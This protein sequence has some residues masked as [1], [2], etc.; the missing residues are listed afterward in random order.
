MNQDKAFYQESF[1]LGVLGGGQL[2][3]MMLPIANYMDIRISILDPSSSA[4]CAAL[5]GDFVQ[6][7]F[8]DYETV[9]N[10]GR[11]KD[12]ITIEIENVNVDALDQLKKEGV[13]VC[14]DPSH[15]RLIKDKGL[16]KEFYQANNIATSAFQ[17]IDSDDI[18][19]AQLPIVQKARTGGYDGKGVKVLRN[20]KDLQDRLP[21][22]SVLEELVDIEKELSVIVARSANGEVKTYPIVELVFDPVANLVDY[23]LSPADITQEIT[24]SA[25]QLAMSIVNAM[26]FVG[27]LAVELFL[28]K[29]G[30]V[31][32][33]E[34]APRT[35]NSGHHSIEGNYTSQFE[36]HLRA[37]LGLPL[38]DADVRCHA[39]MVNIVGEPDA[40]GKVKYE[41]LDEILAMPRAYL[42]LY[43]KPDVKPYRKMGHVTV[44]GDSREEV[45]AKANKVKSNLKAKHR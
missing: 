36:Q 34:V 28:S 33:N 35:H 45:I 32:V 37:I 44:L 22:P 39:A 19:E 31:L 25:N 24:E 17:L 20:S 18:T 16:Q 40:L 7:D 4:S 21:G 42:H 6:G 29:D 8:T 9:L 13:S 30:E 15:L 43:G 10:F 14:P 23:L 27:L 26:D 11:D 38:G 2:G 1:S 5:V 12:L 41:G 3:R